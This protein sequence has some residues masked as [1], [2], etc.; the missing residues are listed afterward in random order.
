MHSSRESGF[1]RVPVLPWRRSRNGLPRE[2]LDGGGGGGRGGV[3]QS[4]EVEPSHWG[5]SASLASFIGAHIFRCAYM[6]PN[7]PVALGHVGREDGRS[8]EWDVAAAQMWKGRDD[9]RLRAPAHDRHHRSKAC[10]GSLS[11][12][13]YLCLCA[14]RDCIASRT[15]HDVFSKT[16]VSHECLFHT[17][18]DIECFVYCAM[19]LLH[20]GC[21]P[22]TVSCLASRPIKG[23]AAD[24]RASFAPAGRA[25]L[26]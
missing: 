5:G 19:A 12:V 23:S 17:R 24:A 15:P 26:V 25:I 20:S 2:Q 10:P 22:R 9:D 13:M 14:R 1:L 16:P 6:H 7:E 18:L 11:L 4:A 21:V 8:T 3:G